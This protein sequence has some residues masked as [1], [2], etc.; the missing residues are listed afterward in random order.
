MKY[1]V[2]NENFNKMET[3]INNS[4]EHEKLTKYLY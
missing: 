3:L 1:P 4:S 2:F